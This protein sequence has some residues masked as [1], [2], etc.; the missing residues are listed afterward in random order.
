MQEFYDAEQTSYSAEEF[1]VHEDEFNEEA[2]AYLG[3]SSGDPLESEDDATRPFAAIAK[4]ALVAIAAAVLLMQVFNPRWMLI[5]DPVREVIG[6]G[7]HEHTPSGEWLLDHDAT[8]TE[9]GIEYMICTKCKEKIDEKEIPATGHSI[10]DKWTV[11]KEPTCVEPGEEAREC[12]ICGEPLETKEIPALGHTKAKDWTVT[13]EPTC[14]KKG[15]K[16]KVCT[17]CGEVLEKKDVAATGHKFGGWTVI[18]YSTCTTHGSEK[19]KCSVCG[20]EETRDR[21]LLK[22]DYYLVETVQPTC[23]SNGYRLYRCSMCG[24]QYTETLW[25][26]GH[27]FVGAHTPM[28]YYAY[29]TRCGKRP[30]EL[31]G[32]AQYRE[33]FDPDSGTV[34][35]YFDVWVDGEYYYAP[36]G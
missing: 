32:S 15:E 13:K 18:T 19:R 12:I 28:E 10:S 21:A 1:F 8:C 22:H 24:A 14:T 17:V 11:E 7:K 35:E 26:T 31:G 5:P 30:E 2:M 25:A 3:E 16:V 36:M 27:S 29:C 33:N 20:Y 4:G 34:T 9:N 23:T 6:I